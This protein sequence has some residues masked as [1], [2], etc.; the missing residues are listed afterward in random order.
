MLWE[1]RLKR[2]T[3]NLQ[4]ALIILN[5]VA[6]LKRL[7]GYEDLAKEYG[8]LMATYKN[9]NNQHCNNTEISPTQR[10]TERE[11]LS[12]SSPSTTS[13]HENCT[14]RFWPKAC[15]T[16]HA[17]A[18]PKYCWWAAQTEHIQIQSQSYAQRDQTQVSTRM[19]QWSFHATQSISA[20]P[21]S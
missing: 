17:T 7:H 15:E 8:L 13:R 3:A 4:P 19:K 11:S 1:T 12:L 10:A 6:I 5:I 21:Q 2:H 18:T 14:G 9:E 16:M 20:S